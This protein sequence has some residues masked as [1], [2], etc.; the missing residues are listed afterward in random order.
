MP[1]DRIQRI[2]REGHGRKLVAAFHRHFPGAFVLLG[3]E[4]V[5]DPGRVEHRRIEDRMPADQTLLRQGEVV[6]GR[7]DHQRRGG[8]GGREPPHRAARDHEVVAVVIVEMA[9][10]AEQRALAFVDEQE[11]VAVAVAGEPGHRLVELPDAHL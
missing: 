4:G 7:L 10:V 3:A 2:E 8:L 11:L 1:A 9:V 6:V 5:V